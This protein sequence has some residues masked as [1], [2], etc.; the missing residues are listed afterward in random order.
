[1]GQNPGTGMVL[2]RA[3]IRDR[4]DW[5]LAGMQCLLQT[6]VMEEVGEP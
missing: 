5:I 6:Q 1:M 4:Q 2:V 3:R